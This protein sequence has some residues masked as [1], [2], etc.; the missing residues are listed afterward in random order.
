MR[1][2]F[3]DVGR[4]EGFGY[5]V[6]LT[7]AAV[8]A[9][10]EAWSAFGDGE[11]PW[12]TISGTIG[13]LEY[14]HPATALIVVGVIVFVGYYA[15]RYPTE[16][17]DTCNR[18]EG[19]RLTRADRPRAMVPWWLFFPVAV[20]AVAAGSALAYASDPHDK[21]R[22]GR[23]FY[24][25]IGLFWVVLPTLIAFPRRGREAP[26]TTLFQ[27]L[28]NLERQVRLL[29]VVLAWGLVVLVIHLVLYPWPAIIPDLKDLHDTYQRQHPNEQLQPPPG[30]PPSPSAP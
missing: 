14:R 25:L 26:F 23:T 2:R 8:V 11:A 22:L 29:A 4:Q 20:A 21:Y 1:E 18:T 5:L 3:H 6:W 9:V 27:T 16:D 7:T 13:E 12:P 17:A 24:G 15:F 30:T 19:G 28:R 10:P